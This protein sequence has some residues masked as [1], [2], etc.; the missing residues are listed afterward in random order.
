MKASYIIDVINRNKNTSET[1]FAYRTN[2]PETTGR[3][4][5]CGKKLEKKVHFFCTDNIIYPPR[6]NRGISDCAYNFYMA[7]PDMI[8]EWTTQ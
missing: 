1:L 7:H 2:H 4:L 8:L 6:Q 5:F 3:C